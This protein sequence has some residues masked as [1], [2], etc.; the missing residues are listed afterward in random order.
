[1]NIFGALAVRAVLGHGIPVHFLGL[2]HLID[3]RGA[4]AR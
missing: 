3:Q 2:G 4:R 1:M